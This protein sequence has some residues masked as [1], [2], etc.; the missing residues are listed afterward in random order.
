[1]GKPAKTRT[2]GY[3][4]LRI[5][6]LAGAG[7]AKWPKN[8][9]VPALPVTRRYPQ[10][11]YPW[12]F[13]PAD[14]GFSFGNCKTRGYGCGLS[15]DT[16]VLNL[17]ITHTCIHGYFDFQKSYPYL[18]TS[19]RKGKMPAGNRYCGFL[20]YLAIPAPANICICRLLN[21]WI[22]VLAGFPTDIP[23]GTCTYLYPLLFLISV[24][25][26]KNICNFLAKMEKL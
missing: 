12:E 10:V 23:A 2:R 9:Q 16:P 6:M 26:A 3:N 18:P 15:T 17:G 20:G 13:K 25:Q 24:C 8:L 19:V 22:Q 11:F 7:M 1:M 21:L 4:N 14:T 5:R